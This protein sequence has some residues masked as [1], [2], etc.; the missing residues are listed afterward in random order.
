[1][2]PYKKKV[3]YIRFCI[4]KLNP[5]ELCTNGTCVC[6]SLCCILLSVSVQFSRRFPE[7]EPPLNLY[8]TVPYHLSV[9]YPNMSPDDGSK[10]NGRTIFLVEVL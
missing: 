10:L 9:A 5:T 1:M 7:N 3:G 2:H 6:L 4:K 8:L